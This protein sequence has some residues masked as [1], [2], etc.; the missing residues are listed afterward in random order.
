[1]PTVT[2]GATPDTSEHLFFAPLMTE[3]DG[4]RF[5]RGPGHTLL[6]LGVPEARTI[7]D[8]LG[9]TKKFLSFLL[10]LSKPRIL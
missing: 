10:L 6:D 9:L 1:M 5:S 3:M 8:D 4:M 2:P 7:S